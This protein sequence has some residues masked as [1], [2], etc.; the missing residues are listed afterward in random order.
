LVGTGSRGGAANG[1]TP[2]RGYT[3]TTHFL[4]GSSIYGSSD[5]PARQK[6]LFNLGTGLMVVNAP[7]L[8]YVPSFLFL[9][10]LVNLTTA[11]LALLWSWFLLE[12]RDLVIQVNFQDVSLKMNGEPLVIPEETNTLL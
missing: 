7:W 6:S 3:D 9:L 4:D 8:L 10:V 12:I 11:F 1:N 2:K 5:D